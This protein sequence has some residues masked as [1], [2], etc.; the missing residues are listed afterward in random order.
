MLAIE[1]VILLL[2]KL[3]DNIF[4]DFAFNPQHFILL[5]ECAMLPA[6]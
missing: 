4:I 1:D 5:Q 6:V 3:N 2:P